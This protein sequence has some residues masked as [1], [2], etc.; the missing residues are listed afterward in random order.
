MGFTSIVCDSSSLISFSG[1]CLADALRFAHSQMNA[2]LYITPGVKNE[3]VAHPLHVPSHE[4]SALR[5]KKLV[6]DRV[7]DV[8]AT[9]NLQ[10]QTRHLLSLA[11]SLFVVRG[12]PLE[13]MQEGETECLAVFE[14]V[15]ASALLVDEKTTRMLVEAPLKL[16][17]AMSSEY[18]GRVTLNEDALA[19]WRELTKGIFIM[20]SSELLALC[21]ERGFF[22]QYGKYEDAALHS[23]LLALRNAGC[24]LTTNE[25][26]E[27][28]QLRV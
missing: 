17:D 13:I 2:R 16:F 11:N 12:E 24:S 6:D 22:R 5:L 26:R 20:R 9:P 1:T 14:G 27:Y 8:I 18:E 25:L 3:I 21:A 19:Q 4:F 28:G 23:A 15:S 10:R 7:L